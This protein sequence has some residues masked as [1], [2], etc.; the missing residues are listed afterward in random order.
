MGMAREAETAARWRG[1]RGGVG[2]CCCSRGGCECRS[3]TGCSRRA[4]DGLKQEGR[5][6]RRSL[7]QAEEEAWVVG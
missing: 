1:G 3:S 6:K 2:G 5:K 7:V 4:N